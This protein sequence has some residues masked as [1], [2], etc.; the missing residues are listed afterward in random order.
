VTPEKEYQRRLLESERQ[1]SMGQVAAFVAHEI[2]T[3]L[4]NI[5]LLSANIARAVSD[6]TVLDRLT[7][8]DAQ[9]RTAANIV[10]ELLSLTRSQDVTR[11]PVDLRG[12]IDAAIEQTAGFRKPD[13]RL[14]Q[15]LPREPLIFPVDPI[16]MQQVV[17]NLLKNAYQATGSGSVTVRLRSE[18]DHVMIAVLDTGS[19]IDP[20][21]KARLFQPFV[22]TKPRSEGLGLGLVFTKQVIEGHAGSIQVVS[23]P[24]RGSTFTITLPKAPN[25][26]SGKDAKAAA[27]GTPKAP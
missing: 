10:S 19:G 4:T 16:R 6:P 5:A 20:E 18:K 25:G 23:E 22:T 13:V 24:G 11:I 12:V 17:V 14:V 1:A 3:P 21:M 15:E 7:K 26:G 8:I 27:V 9:R 2:N